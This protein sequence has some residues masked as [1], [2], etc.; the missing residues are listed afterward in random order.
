MCLS[1][2]KEFRT[3][4]DEGYK[5]FRIRGGKLST[6]CAGKRNKL[7]LRGRW[8]KA[9][10]WHEKGDSRKDQVWYPE[11]G[12]PHI[13]KIGWHILMSKQG[14]RGWYE[15]KTDKVF[16]VKYRDVS[17]KGEQSKDNIVVAQ[18]MLIMEEVH[19]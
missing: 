10:D 16:R 5:V 12:A 13:Y 7:L 6:L 8:L 2:L 19:I 1:K 14:A 15:K 17:A 4:G 9:K 18:E 3:I 11:E